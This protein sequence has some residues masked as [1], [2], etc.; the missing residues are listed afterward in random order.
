[1]GL[2][3]TATKRAFWGGVGT[4][5]GQWRQGIEVFAGFIYGADTDTLQTA[6]LIVDFVQGNSIFSSMTGKLTPMPHTPLYV[7]LKEQG[8]LVEDGDAQNNVDEHLQYEPVMGE[9][10]LHEG[11]SHI[12]ASLF[13][14]DALYDRARGLLDLIQALL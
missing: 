7:E 8:R 11:F 5:Q 1:M 13:N 9:K 2:I 12:L 3:L 6:D 14:V 10:N 4:K